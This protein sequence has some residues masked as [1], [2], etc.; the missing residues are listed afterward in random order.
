[1]EKK[2]SP[3]AWLKKDLMAQKLLEM[4]HL[5]KETLLPLM[6]YMQE[7]DITF[8]KIAKKMKISQPNAWK[9]Y[10]RAKNEILRSFYTLK[11]AL[12]AGVLDEKVA[13]LIKDDLLDY[14]GL[15]RNEVDEHEAK[16]R[17]EK[18]MIELISRLR[19]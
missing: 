1:M 10:H 13:D 11:L 9:R 4:S 17:M 3:E 15:L 5:K 16:Y 7:N 6:Y 18:R 8:D 19:K 12:H 14:L 2:I